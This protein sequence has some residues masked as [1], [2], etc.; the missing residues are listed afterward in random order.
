MTHIFGSRTKM[1]IEKNAVMNNKELLSL[2]K[3]AIIVTSKSAAAVSGALV[4]VTSALALLDIPYAVYSDIAENPTY[5]SVK[6]AS[7]K[8]ID[9]NCDFVIGIGGGSP[10]D[11]A[12]AVAILLTNPDITEEDFYKCNFIVPAPIALIGTTAGTGSEVTPYSVITNSDGKKASVASKD[13]LTI[14][15]FGDIT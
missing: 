6:E 4:D 2:G 5:E 9:E 8:A 14:V 11:A 3:K 10:L 7:Q 1:I 13:I 15:S 12:K